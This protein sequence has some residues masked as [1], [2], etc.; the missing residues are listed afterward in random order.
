MPRS[1][2][3]WTACSTD[4]SCPSS[5]ASIAQIIEVRESSCEMKST[6]ISPPDSSWRR[7]ASFSF[8]SIEM[9]YWIA[10]CKSS[11][12]APF[13]LRAKSLEFFES[14]SS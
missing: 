2:K 1:P 11:G 13:A 8:G 14:F 7:R 9:K 6:G 3:S 5:M 12:V 10:P 4:T